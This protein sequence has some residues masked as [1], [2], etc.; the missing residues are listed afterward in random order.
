MADSES[1]LNPLGA[2]LAGACLRGEY[3]E[4]ADLDAADPRGAKWT[5]TTW[6]DRTVINTGWSP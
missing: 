4:R 2:D 6:P 1:R 3:F 5:N